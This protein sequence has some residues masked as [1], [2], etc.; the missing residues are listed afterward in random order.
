V[1][2]TFKARRVSPCYTLGEMANAGDS[3]LDKAES[4]A[5]RILERLGS[6]VDKKIAPADQ[7]SLSSS[8][9]GDL[10]S[11]LEHLVDSSL[12]EDDRGTRRVAPN[13]FKVLFTYEETSKLS[14]Q[15]I[16]AVGKELTATIFE[17]INNRRYATQGPVEVT[18]ERDLFTKSTFVRATFDGDAKSQTPQETAAA[19]DKDLRK[20]SFLASDGRTYMI[21]LRAAAAPAYVGRAAGNAITIDDENVSRLHCSLSLRSGGAV[22]IADVGSAN[23]TYV[24]EQ[25]LGRDEAR[26][27]K[28]GDVIAVGDCKLTVSG[29]R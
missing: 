27:L 7:L 19:Q 2:G 12:K 22:V 21:E 20:A 25:L 4:L 17:Y 10:A 24:N 6:K 29:I 5:R 14:P 15:Y 8:Q 18:A 26:L 13:R 9:I 16:E 23:G 28:P 3:V 1:T 11:R